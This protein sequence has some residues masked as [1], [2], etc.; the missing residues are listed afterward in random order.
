[1]VY[2]KNDYQL[3]SY[4]IS[5]NIINQVEQFS[6]KVN[7]SKDYIVSMA[8]KTFMDR[9]EKKQDLLDRINSA[10]QTEFNYEETKV[11]EQMQNLHIEIT[12]EEQW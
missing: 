11:F 8:I 1:M 10:N 3:A 9:Y 6:L 2:S 5:Q 12:E 4:L 7:I